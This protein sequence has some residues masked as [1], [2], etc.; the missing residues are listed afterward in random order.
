LR[1]S[2]NFEQIKERNLT[3]IEN[4]VRNLKLKRNTE[5]IVALANIFTQSDL[6]KRTIRLIGE[7]KEIV[8]GK[9]KYKKINL[10]SL[11]QKSQKDFSEEAINHIFQDIGLIAPY[12][13]QLKYMNKIMDLEGDQVVTYSDL[14]N[15]LASTPK[16]NI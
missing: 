12:H 7:D 16:I 2:M 14:A 15:I 4:C 9:V 13:T 6:N 3:H 10:F 5:E 8:E 1:I 11:T